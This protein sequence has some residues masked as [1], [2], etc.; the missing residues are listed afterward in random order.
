MLKQCKKTTNLA[1]NKLEKIDNN[2]EIPRW[3]D[4]TSKI[5]VL[6]LETSNNSDQS[7]NGKESNINIFLFLKEKQ[8]NRNLEIDLTLSY[9]PINFD[10]CKLLLI[11]DARENVDRGGS[12]KINI[13]QHL[14]KLGV[15]CY[16]SR[17][18]SVGDYLWVLKLE[19]GKDE[20]VLDYIVERK[21]WD[22]LKV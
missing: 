16:E 10:R 13:T 19:N 2:F 4:S 1:L 9:N 7:T 15:V 22:D 17:P 20:M 18:L 12:R 14:D 21:T 5:N 11:I 8:F 3:Q 6:S